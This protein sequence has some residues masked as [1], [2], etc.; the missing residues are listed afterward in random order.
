MDALSSVNAMTR[1]ALLATLILAAGC[2][3][4]PD[5]EA[6]PVEDTAGPEA[7]QP[8][9]VFW[10]E[11]N[12]QRLGAALAVGP[13]AVLVISGP[14]RGSESWEDTEEPRIFLLHT[15]TGELRDDAFATIKGGWTHDSGKYYVSS[16]IGTEVVLPGDV[17]GDDEPDVL[18][19]TDDRDGDLEE[20][21]YLFPGPLLGN[22]YIQDAEV[23]PIS[24][25]DGWNGT[26]CGDLD[27]NGVDELC[28]TSGVVFGPV[29]DSPEPT[30]T[31]SGSDAAA[32]GISAA[33][34]DADGVNELIITGSEA[35][36]VVRLSALEPGDVEL[37]SAAEATWTA[38]TGVFPTILAGDD[39]DGD[40][41]G[42]IAV[43][44]SDGTTTTVF[45]LTS[46]GGG[47][48][49]EAAT[50]IRVPTTTMVVGDLDGDQAQDLVVGG[51]GSVRVFMGPLQ[52]GSFEPRDA[53]THLVG[54]EYPDDGFGDALV[55][56]ERDGDLPD[57]LIV[58]APDT[59]EGNSHLT[60][61][62]VFMISGDQL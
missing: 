9:G 39:L 10:R 15:T 41:Q 19:F 2:D 1:Y 22:V 20:P 30:L 58:G 49:N 57:L 59:T 46:P 54:T 38:P 28:L 42:D 47:T 12:D 31:W 43:A 35:S 3:N 7:E 14:S 8:D 53:D 27:G 36:A 52:A 18:L 33:D 13:G 40:G 37:E 21:A 55:T 60:G 6:P 23:L 26:H 56:I 48:I 29:G 61:G 32:L 45:L 62:M 5:S 17:T 11:Y 51:E 50:T 4:Q 24:G 44:W 34:L 25:P 16:R